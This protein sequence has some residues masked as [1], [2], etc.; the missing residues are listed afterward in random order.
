MTEEPRNLAPLRL[1]PLRVK[2][3]LSRSP[4]QKD[5]PR[6][7]CSWPATCILGGEPWPRLS[8]LTGGV[9]RL[10]ELGFRHAGGKCVI[11]R[12]LVLELGCNSTFSTAI[13]VSLDGR[14]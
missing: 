10:T 1:Q 9:C 6:T 7:R 5:Q 2:V 13:L 14:G 12:D 3:P 11:V 8:A 4:E